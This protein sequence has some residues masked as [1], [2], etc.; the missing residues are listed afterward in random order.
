MRKHLENFTLS[1]RKYKTQKSIHT[2]SWNLSLSVEGSM[3]GNPYMLII[4][5]ETMEATTHMTLR[6]KKIKTQTKNKQEQRYA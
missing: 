6:T 4:K 2:N 1:K 3:L 5:P